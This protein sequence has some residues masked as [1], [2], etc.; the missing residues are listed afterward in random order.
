MSKPVAKKHI[1][2]YSFFSQ[3]N[4]FDFSP[5]K[6]VH[7]PRYPSRVSL[8]ELMKDEA[9]FRNSKDVYILDGEGKLV[10]L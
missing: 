9:R 10:V 7:D 6:Y 5:V 8:L 2:K 4:S 1:A 3:G